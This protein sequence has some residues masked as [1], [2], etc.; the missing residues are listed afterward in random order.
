[1]FDG[2]PEPAIDG[3]GGPYPPQNAG[4]YV[5][6]SSLPQLTR[7]EFRGYPLRAIWEDDYPGD[8]R[9]NMRCHNLGR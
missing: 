5:T 6:A 3:Y 7:L 1:M 9:L 4:D 2:T 8:T